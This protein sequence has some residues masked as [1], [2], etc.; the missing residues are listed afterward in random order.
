MWAP[1]PNLTPFDSILLISHLLLFIS[2][3]YG[4]GHVITATSLGLPLSLP[5]YTLLLGAITIQ[6]RVSL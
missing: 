6:H 4:S 5:R 3:H 1:V 2:N